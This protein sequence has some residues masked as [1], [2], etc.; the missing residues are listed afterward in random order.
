[1]VIKNR[2]LLNPMSPHKEE[3]RRRP[4]VEEEVAEEKDNREISLSAEQ[5]QQRPIK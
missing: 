3:E 2:N 4:E 1:M 5:F